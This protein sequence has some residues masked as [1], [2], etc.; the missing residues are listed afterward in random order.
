MQSAKKIHIQTSIRVL[1]GIIIGI[2]LILVFSL[3]K[4]Q[5]ID[6]DEYNPRSQN[7]ALR[8]E[9]IDPTRG[10]ILDRNGKT[11]VS[12]VPIYSITVTPA[13]FKPESLPLLASL[14]NVSE[15]EIQS[16]ID[17]GLKDNRLRPVRVIS[18]IDFDTFSRIQ[19]NIWRLQ[20]VSHQIE[21]KRSYTFGVAGSHIFGYLREVT[22][23]ELSQFGDDY[24]LG[25][26]S[27]KSGIE[28]VYEKSLRG[29]T[30]TNLIRVTARGRPLGPYQNGDHDTAPVKGSD[31]TTS[32]DK[33]LQMLAEKLM[34]NKIG[35]L[36]AMDPQN[37]EILAMVSAPQF[38]LNKLS[39]K[40]DRNYWAEINSDRNR[41]LFNR[42]VSTRQP[43][44]STFKPIMG[45]IGLDLG[46]I[47]KDTRVFCAGGFSKG[48]L[49]RCTGSHGS[50]NLEEAILFSC[51]TYFFDLM[52]KIGTRKR[53]LD[54][55]NHA[56]DLGLGIKN[57]IDI[58][59]ETSGI[60][61]DSSYFNRAFGVGRWG[62]GD[63][64]NLGV[65]QGVISVSPL[66]VAVMISTIANGGYRVQPHVVR[67]ITDIDGTVTKTVPEK[68][69][70]EWLNTET[71][72][73]V[74]RGMYRVVQE[75]AGRHYVR[76]DTVKAAG[77]T[78]T[79]QNPH[80]KDHGWFVG[81]APFDNP[82]IVV[83][84][85]VENAGSGQ[86]AASPIAGL[87]IEQYIHGKIKR[88]AL[89]EQI[90]NFNPYPQRLSP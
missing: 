28:L 77:K 27:G 19:E 34:Q 87:I 35:G 52:D 62:I 67:S 82:K 32:I 54:W 64:I 10:Q 90:A 48:R 14:L 69:K 17:Q 51:N 75:G 12:N 4:M 43:P 44:A 83:A 15:R 47:N 80:G 74:R 33:D 36:V 20:G 3:F 61:P 30:G 16:I 37:G 81:F 8:R 9:Y 41:P 40:I 6:Y 11:M 24:R 66:Q 84:V 18:D 65:G 60:I 76:I 22:K 88:T 46:L 1:Q 23:D 89:A 71:L 68:Q 25:D 73:P 58:P 5:I 21:S 45:I 72:D 86:A 59:Q 13:D 38:D 31:I 26:I 55:K 2:S 53:F 50:V 56:N 85:I 79:A 39:G 49:Y 63:V 42:A 57:G 29:I 7:N 70:V 78:G